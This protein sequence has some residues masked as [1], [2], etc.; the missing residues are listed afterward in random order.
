MYPTYDN[1][2]FDYCVSNLGQGQCKIVHKTEGFNGFYSPQTYRRHMLCFRGGEVVGMIPYQYQFH[3]FKEGHKVF[4][5]CVHCGHFTDEC[6]HGKWLRNHYSPPKPIKVKTRSEEKH[7][8]IQ[9]EY[10]I[11]QLQLESLQAEVDRLTNDTS[12]A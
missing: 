9:H 7:E 11:N 1:S 5:L 8:V 10:L 6:D 3:A 2:Y 4:P 12:F